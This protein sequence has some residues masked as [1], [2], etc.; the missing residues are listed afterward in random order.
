MDHF[1]YRDGVLHAEDVPLPAIAQAVGTPVYVYSRA[2]LTR[3]ARVPRCAG[4]AA[5]REDRV[6]GQVQPQPGRAARARRRRLWRGCRVGGELE[7][8]LAAGMAADGIVFS[9][10][11]KT[12]AEMPR[13]GSG[14]GQFNLESEEEG[15]NSPRSPRRWARSRRR[16]CA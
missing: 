2:T 3:H 4:G 12:E 10:V 14:I 7:R 11:G 5:A 1:D 8:A 6:C 16:R 13:A 9:G 15:W